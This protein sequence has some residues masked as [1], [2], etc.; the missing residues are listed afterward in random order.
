MTVSFLH[1]IKTKIKFHLN[2]PLSVCLSIYLSFNANLSVFYPFLFLTELL[3]RIYFTEYYMKIIDILVLSL[4]QYLCN[5]TDGWTGPLAG[6]VLFSIKLWIRVSTLAWN[7]VFTQRRKFLNAL[8]INI[9]N[10]VE[11]MFPLWVRFWDQY[12]LLLQYGI[13][14]KLVTSIVLLR[15]GIVVLGKNARHSFGRAQD[16]IPLSTRKNWPSH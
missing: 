2:L 12:S 10:I 1:K 5:G 16:R 13:L 15:Q 6:L 14:E 11:L 7:S 8:L 9:S 3:F 4:L